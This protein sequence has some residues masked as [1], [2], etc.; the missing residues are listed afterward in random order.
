MDVV[1]P[2]DVLLVEDDPGDVDLTRET[3]EESKILANLH[4]VE[5]GIEAMAFLRKEG[6]YADACTPDMI[7]L[8]LNMPRMDGRQVLEELRQDETLKAIPVVVLTTS[9]SD[10]DIV[11]SYNLGANCYVAKPTGLDEFMK[12]VKS[13]ENFWFTVVKLPTKVKC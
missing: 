1:R 11:R 5:N 9:T 10:E 4:V 13:I 3:M 8:D 6:V 2:I 7:L 12:V